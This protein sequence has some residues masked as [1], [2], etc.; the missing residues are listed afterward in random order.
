[1]AGI[2]TG[3]GTITALTALLPSGTARYVALF[4][5]LPNQDGSSGVEVTGS[6]YARATCS[7]WSMA[8]GNNARRQNGTAVTFAA[9]TGAVS[10]VVGWG[11]YDAASAGNL[12]AFGPVR[13]TASGLATTRN[14]I[15]TD[16]PS[17]P[18]GELWVSIEAGD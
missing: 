3:T 11:I 8:S 6:G 14:F 12:L 4:T 5:T 7:S 16:Q 2:T 18:A 1:M 9:L 15:A 13:A 10:G 17:F